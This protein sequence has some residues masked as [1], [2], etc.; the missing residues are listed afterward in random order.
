M[1]KRRLLGLLV[2]VIAAAIMLSGGGEAYAEG[3]RGIVRGDPG[4]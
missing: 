2:V 1:N 4:P 3:T